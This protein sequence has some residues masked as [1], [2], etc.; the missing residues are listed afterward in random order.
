MSGPRRYSYKEIEAATRGF[1]PAGKL[2][3]G[4]FGEVYRGTLGGEPVAVKRLTQAAGV[5]TLAGLPSADQFEAEVLKAGAYTHPHLLPVIGFCDEDGVG[6]GAPRRSCVVYPLMRSNLEDQLSTEQPPLTYLERAR[7]FADVLDGVRALHDPAV[8]GETAVHRDIKTAN[9]LLDADRRA[10][11]GDFGLVRE[12]SGLTASGGARSHVTTANQIG[13]TQYMAPEYR[14]H[15]E[16]SP[17]T[18]VYACGIVALELFTGLPS[19]PDGDATRDLK[20]RMEDL[21]Y[22]LRDEGIND[23]TTQRAM[24]YAD[25]KAGWPQDIAMKFVKVA[26]ECLHER[27]SKRLDSTACHDRLQELLASAGHADRPQAPRRPTQAW[28]EMEGTAS[29]SGAMQSASSS[30]GGERGT[31]GAGAGGGERGRVADQ[32]T[33]EVGLD[34]KTPVLVPNRGPGPS[35]CTFASPTHFFIQT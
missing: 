8:C 17:K 26:A 11:V 20:R 15:G 28:G 12:I 32:P 24:E 10:L 9:V 19:R 7:I 4:G 6:P 18:D 21:L 16:I 25:K 27:V 1:N 34:P 22:D 3:E 5:G 30:G 2:G 35:H 33:D 29:Q 13:T 23:T 14:D 31:A